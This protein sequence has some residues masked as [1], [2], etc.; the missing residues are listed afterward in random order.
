MNKLPFLALS[1]LLLVACSNNEEHKKK[2]E[3]PKTEQHHKDKKE[4]HKEKE[5]SKKR[6]SHKITQLIKPRTINKLT[7][8]KSRH[9]Y[10]TINQLIIVNK[11]R[12]NRQFNNLKMV[13]LKHAY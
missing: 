7:I 3:N 13:M 8:D 2:V 4:E 1:A 6:L 5:T 11:C 9:N 12:I 10:K